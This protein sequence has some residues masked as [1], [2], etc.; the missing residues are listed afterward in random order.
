[1]AYVTADVGATVDVAEALAA[2]MQREDVLLLRGDVGAGKTTLA[3]AVVRR[4]SNDDALDVPSPTYLIQRTYAGTPEVH[5][6]DLYRLGDAKNA[7]IGAARTSMIDLGASF[8]DAITLVEWPDRVD[9]QAAFP[10][11]RFEVDIESAGD[12]D[13]SEDAD[14]MR[15][16]T[17]RATGDG[18][19]SRLQA[20][21]DAM[22]ASPSAQAG[23]LARV[24]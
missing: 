18:H 23:A 16:L 3:R 10:R 22:D 4:R 1:M 8:R 2:V 11:E 17:L 24:L 7:A 15:H 13:D 6:Y 14:F 9:A 12:D 20:A 21:A 19:V 5:H